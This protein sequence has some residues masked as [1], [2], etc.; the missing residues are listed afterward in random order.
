MT[1]NIFNKAPGKIEVINAVLWLAYVLAM[2]SSIQHLAWTFGTVERSGQEWLG[3][4]PALAVDAGLAALAYTIQQRKRTQRSTKTLWAGLIGFALISAGA[5]FYHAIFAHGVVEHVDWMLITKAVVLSATLPALVVYLGEVVSS[6]DAQASN[7]AEQEQQRA[8]AKEER[9]QRR[10]DKRLELAARQLELE[11]QRLLQEQQAA[12]TTATTSS[13]E[14][15]CE[16]CGNTFRNRQAYAA[17]ACLK[18]PAVAAIVPAPE[19]ITPHRNG[20]H[21]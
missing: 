1:Q 20:R 4:V 8:A 11:Q 13:T 21:A 2:A 5:N 16:Q 7:K 9:E 17:H 6:D 19:A 14:R 18:K 15:T 10:E 3:W 12:T